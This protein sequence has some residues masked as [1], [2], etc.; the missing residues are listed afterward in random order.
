MFRAS[1]VFVGSLCI[2]LGVQTYAAEEVAPSSKP[3]SRI[4]FNPALYASGDGLTPETAVILK[5]RSLSS[6]V[7]S[8]Y[9]WIQHHYPSAKPIQQYLTPWENG[10]R[11]DIIVIRPAETKEVWL[12]FDIS[13]MYR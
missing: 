13:E 12:W 10:K 7:S 9:T 4:T 1:A 3:K 2:A 6:G 5:S 8:E 11:F